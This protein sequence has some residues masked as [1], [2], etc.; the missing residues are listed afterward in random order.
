MKTIWRLKKGFDR[1]IR[2]HHPWVFSNELES[3][4]KGHL[5]GAP[6]ELRNHQDQLVAQG[7]G[8]PHSLISFRALQ[9]EESEGDACSLNSIREKLLNSW[10]ARRKMGFNGSFRLCFGEGDQIP[11][12]VVDYYVAR[13]KS[14]LN[15][16][17]D[18]NKCAQI[19]CIQILTAGM[20]S[21]F[22]LGNKNSEIAFDSLIQLFHEL[23]ETAQSQGISSFEWQR[24]GIVLRND[25]SVRKL[26]G[27]E[28]DPP[29]VVRKPQL[30]ENLSEVVAA[31]GDYKNQEPKGLTSIDNKTFS[32][33]ESTLWLACDLIE[34]QKTGFFLDQTH[35]ISLVN[36]FV[37]EWAIVSNFSETN[38][39]RILDLCCYVGHWST[40]LTNTLFKTLYANKKSL[41]IEVTLVDVSETALEFATFNVKNN[42]NNLLRNFSEKN[43]NLEIKVISRKLNVASELDQLPTGNYDI[44]IADPPAFIKAKKDL[45]TGQHAYL[46]LGTHSFRLVK[47]NGF[48]VSCS[49]SGL[50]EDLDFRHSLAKS[51]L[52]NRKQARCVVRGGHAADHP[53]LLSFPEGEYLKMYTHFVAMG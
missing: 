17:L 39:I 20:N 23:T 12:L 14:D 46:K 29:K 32:N 6:V 51:I 24:T 25:V 19:F 50:L 30:I 31:I 49:C 18:E 10:M 37:Q 15:S 27:L 28:V 45:P 2:S 34:G 36:N 13:N 22:D 21:L 53:T 1:R 52:R 40:R 26:E 3:S 43:R 44:V 9:F 48:V 42:L 41:T 33:K 7:Y 35:N 16:N 11:G 4:P 47:G 38:C 5:P 8:N